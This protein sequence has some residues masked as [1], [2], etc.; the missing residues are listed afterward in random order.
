MYKKCTI[1]KAVPVAITAQMCPFNLDAV[2]HATLFVVWNL[3]KYQMGKNFFAE[4]C[5]MNFTK[6]IAF[7]AVFASLMLTL[8]C[9]N[10]TADPTAD[11]SASTV[12]ASTVQG[13]QFTGKAD[14]ADLSI[15]IADN[16]LAK[17]VNGNPYGAPTAP[18]GSCDATFDKAEIKITNFNYYGSSSTIDILCEMDPELGAPSPELTLLP[19]GSAPDGFYG[20]FPL[21]SNGSYYL[22]RSF[23]PP[24]IEAQ[25]PHHEITRIDI[26]DDVTFTCLG[27]DNKEYEVALY[28]TYDPSALNIPS[29]LNT[30]D[31]VFTGVISV[32]LKN[33]EDNKIDLFFE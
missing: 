20:Y 32:N 4:V 29:V 16:Y 9:G 7:T 31:E 8:A 25:G 12:D 23:M 10:N 18:S 15:I 33:H 6:K 3:H 11:A 13:L 14:G 30:Q 27:S 26:R 22:L 19:S 24:V 1:I 28:G 17:V 2:V 21:C 5:Y